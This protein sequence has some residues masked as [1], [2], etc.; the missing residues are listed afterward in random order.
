MRRLATGADTGNGMNL[1]QDVFQLKGGWFNQLP[2]PVKHDVLAQG[3][4]IALKNNQRLYSRGDS[5]DGIYAVL[6]GTMRI[7]GLSRDGHETVLD[8]HGPGAWFGEVCIDGRPRSN[9]ARAHGAATVL[10]I[11]P[12]N[13]ERLLM[14]HAPLSRGLLTMMAQRLRVLLHSVESYSTQNMEQRLAN[15]LLLLSGYYGV[16]THEGLLIDLHLSQETLAKLIGSTRQRVNQIL[17]LWEGAELVRQRYGRVVL[18]NPRRLE[19]IAHL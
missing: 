1:H 14:Q 10:R 17:K 13:L 3:T 18:T 7:S 8:F 11:E 19:D 16:T 6:E 5:P 15:R 12:D 2:D 9:D 4:V